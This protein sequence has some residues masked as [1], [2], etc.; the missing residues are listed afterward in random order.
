MAGGTD[1][2]ALEKEGE[3]T[4]KLGTGRVCVCVCVRALHNSLT[5]TPRTVCGR[6]VVVDQSRGPSTSP[7][8]S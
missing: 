7:G 6:T 5:A 4:K 3:D 2:T 8:D 1:D